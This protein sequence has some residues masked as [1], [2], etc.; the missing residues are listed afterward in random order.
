MFVPKE[1]KPQGAGGNQPQEQ[2]IYNLEWEEIQSGTAY[3]V[4]PGEEVVFK[5]ID[6]PKRVKDGHASVVLAEVV[7]WKDKDG[8]IIRQ[9]EKCPIMLPSLSFQYTTSASTTDA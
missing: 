7:Y 4:R 8:N 3:L 1:K 9:N 5:P 2:D 6:A